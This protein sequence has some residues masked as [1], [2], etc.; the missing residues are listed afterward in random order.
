MVVS[1]SGHLVKNKKCDWL[2]LDSHLGSWPPS[3]S[4][5][6]H[7]QDSSKSYSP[8]KS[9][10]QSGVLWLIQKIQDVVIVLEKVLDQVS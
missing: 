6:N 9:D 4:I 3:K 10:K 2:Y 8:K 5:P 7:Q 1:T